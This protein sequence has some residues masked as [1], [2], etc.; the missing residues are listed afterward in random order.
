MEKEDGLIKTVRSV[1]VCCSNDACSIC[2]ENIKIKNL[3]E[4]CTK[5][6]FSSESITA[7]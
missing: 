3:V 7:N 4:S 6:L 2:M 5:I 1:C